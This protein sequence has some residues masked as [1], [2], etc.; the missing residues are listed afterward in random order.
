[1]SK[2]EGMSSEFQIFREVYE[3]MAQRIAFYDAVFN[4]L[5]K[6]YPE[7][8]GLLTELRSELLDPLSKKSVDEW[9]ENIL[10]YIDDEAGNSKQI[11]VSLEKRVD[12][13]SF[14]GTMPYVRGYYEHK[15]ITSMPVYGSSGKST[16]LIKTAELEK[17][18]FSFIEILA[19]MTEDEYYD[20]ASAK[21]YTTS[22]NGS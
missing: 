9:I 6:L 11:L 15:E 16:I 12:E 5:S 4:V 22:W 18:K 1:M 10:E 14:T 13:A 8:V 17:L 20:L 3:E 7:K 21:I 19:L 2:T